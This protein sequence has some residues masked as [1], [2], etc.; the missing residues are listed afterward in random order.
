ME[1]DVNLSIEDIKRIVNS[2]NLEVIHAANKRQILKKILSDNR[3]GIHYY[4]IHYETGRNGMYRMG[5]WCCMIIDNNRK[6]VL[7]FDSMGYFPDNQTR[8]IRQEVKEE[9]DQLERHIGKFLYQ[10]AKLGYKI[11]YNEIAFQKIGSNT[12]GRY[13]ALVFNLSKRKIILPQELKKIL[14]KFK[15]EGTYDEVVLRYVK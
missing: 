5:H 12:C 3:L 1:E 10:L 8:L 14:D 11:Y 6:E 9:T 13:C 7:F 2:P 4:L 15:H